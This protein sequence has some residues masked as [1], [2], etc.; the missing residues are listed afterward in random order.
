M[1][2]CKFLLFFFTMTL[3]LR[4][5][6]ERKMLIPS[7]VIASLLGNFYEAVKLILFAMNFLYNV[8]ISLQLSRL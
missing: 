8:S 3:S 1:L 7:I 5:I 6:N 4:N 2:W